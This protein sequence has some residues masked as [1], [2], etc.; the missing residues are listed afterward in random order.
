MTI[1]NIHEGEKDTTTVL[2]DEE[3][4]EVVT[5]VFGIPLDELKRG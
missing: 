4:I 1:E 5:N 3:N 2:T